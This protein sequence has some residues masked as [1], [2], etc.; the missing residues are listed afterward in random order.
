MMGVRVD[1]YVAYSFLSDYK[2]ACI[3]VRRFADGEGA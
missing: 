2:V 1:S 3:Y